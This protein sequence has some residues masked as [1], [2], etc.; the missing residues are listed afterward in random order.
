LTPVSLGKQRFRTET[1]ALLGCHSI[2]LQY[3]KN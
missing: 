2:F 3:Q 1:A